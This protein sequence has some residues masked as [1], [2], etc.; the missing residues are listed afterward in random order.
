MKLPAETG[1]WLPRESLSCRLPSLLLTWPSR[2]VPQLSLGISPGASLADIPKRDGCILVI[3]EL[4]LTVCH[5]I[6]LQC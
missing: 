1:I 5:G 6:F 4:F 3:P 2:S